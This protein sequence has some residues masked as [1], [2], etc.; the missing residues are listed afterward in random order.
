[1]NVNGMRPLAKRLLEQAQQVIDAFPREAEMRAVTVSDVPME[2][3]GQRDAAGPEVW[4]ALNT[5]HRAIEQLRAGK[6]NPH[7]LTEVM[8]AVESLLKA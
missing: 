3:F 4:R 5:L 8:S 6:S 2:S 1:M 7:E